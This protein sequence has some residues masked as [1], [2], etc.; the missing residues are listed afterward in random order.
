[1]NGVRIING[2]YA[3][4]PNPREGGMAF[5]Y[6]GADMLDGGRQVAVKVFRHD[7]I[8]Q[9]ILAEVFRR[10]TQA[11][12]ELEHPGIV[13]LLDSGVEQ[14]S[15]R[16]FL[17]FEWME[18]D[19]ADRLKTAPPKG[20]D[21]FAKSVALPLLEALAFAHSLNFVHRDLKPGNISGGP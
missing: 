13:K 11:L 3:L 4:A 14:E 5:V 6:R 15:G 16:F 18:S 17:V 1:M 19:L 10:E 12:R 8:E 9:P 20:W 21:D 7:R 2:R